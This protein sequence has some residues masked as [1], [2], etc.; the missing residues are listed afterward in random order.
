MSPLKTYNV[1]ISHSWKYD[2][3]YERF[4]KLLENATYFSWK[5]YS[6]PEY[7]AKLTRMNQELKNA[8][9]DQIRPVNIVIILAGMYVVYSDWIQREIIISNALNKPIIGVYPWGSERM[10]SVVFNASKAIVG[11][12][13]NSIINAIRDHS[14]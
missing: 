5:N 1:F 4:V 13:T 10:P 14:I 6:V 11:W 7:A 2:S 3:E 8:L 9:H 12:N